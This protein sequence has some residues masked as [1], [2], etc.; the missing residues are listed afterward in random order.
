MPLAQWTS[1][2]K[3]VKGAY[4][5]TDAL[6]EIARRFW[7]NELAADF[8]THEGKALAAKLIQDRQTAKECLVVCDHLYPIMEI[9]NSEDHVGDPSLE[10]KLL[11]AVTGNE[12]DEPALRRI[13]E[14]VFNLQRAIHVR[15]GHKGREEDTIP[16]EWHTMPLK[17]GGLDPQRLVP[18]RNGEAI[19][20]IGATVDRQGF[21]QMKDEY[22]KIRGWDVDT[23]FQTREALEGLG[24]KDAAD[25]LEQREFLA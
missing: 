16:N 13:G 12:I 1:W 20:R 2:L 11:S 14:R 7:G 6:K 5:N 15:E 17:K 23:G 8:S 4:L 3:G 21:E 18:G 10:S 9:K 22:Y 19:S 24:L 25:D